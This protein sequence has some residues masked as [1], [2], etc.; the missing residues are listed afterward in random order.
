MPG[1]AEAPTR[2]T[3][4]DYYRSDIKFCYLKLDLALKITTM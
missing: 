3:I 4:Q 2:D 1:Q